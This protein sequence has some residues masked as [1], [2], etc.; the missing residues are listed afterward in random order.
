MEKADSVSTPPQPSLCLNF[1]LRTVGEWRAL[2]EKPVRT[3]W[4]QTIQYA[5]AAHK[6]DQ[7]KTHFATIEQDGTPIGLVAIQEQKL[8]PLHFVSIYRGPLWFEGHETSQNM[9]EF[10]RIFQKAY[11]PRLLRRIR[12]MPEWNFIE[13]SSIDFKKAGLKN[14]NQSFHTLWVDIRPSLAELRKNLAQKWRNALNKA[15]RSD[16]SITA[17]NKGLH[18]D[19]FLKEYDFFKAQKKFQGPS[20]KFFKQEIESALPFK[21]AIILWAKI[22]GIPVAGIVIMK[23]GRSASY[24]LGWNSQLGRDTNAHYLLIWK[25]IEVLKKFN[26]EY[27]DLGGILPDEKEGLTQ[28]KMGLNGESFKTEVFK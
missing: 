13:D 4:M 21:D 6:V 25:A 12:W 22:S 2:L 8:G 23:H 16:I 1:S 28:F 18:L 26:V 10:I 20:G 27:F 14:A 19:H 11:P 9:N 17:D 7:R 15:E 5:S 3:S 24:R